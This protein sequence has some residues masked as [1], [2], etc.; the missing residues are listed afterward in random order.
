MFV[1]F[2]HEAC[3]GLADMARFLTAFIGVVN[4]VLDK[5]GVKE[6]SM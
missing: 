1:C 6:W 5:E 4:F 3:I 2:R